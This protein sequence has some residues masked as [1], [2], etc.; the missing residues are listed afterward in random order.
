M[1]GLCAQDPAPVSI[2]SYKTTHSSLGASIFFIIAGLH[3]GFPL[4]AAAGQYEALCG[5][6]KCTVSVSPSGI[7][8]P[9][10]TIPPQRVTY[11]GNSGESKTSVGTGVATTILFGGIG[12]LGFF[13]K[14]HQYNFFIN[15]Y[16]ANG[17]QVSMQFEFKNDKPVKSLVNEL[18]AVTGLGMNQT[19]TIEDIKAVESAAPSTLGPMVSPQTQP[20]GPVKSIAP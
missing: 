16:D 18:A 20:L 13:A 11:W 3:V 2:F 10:G 19:R 1:L 17:R 7:I 8:S 4:A 12:L 9:F 14:N 6:T 5:G 15:G